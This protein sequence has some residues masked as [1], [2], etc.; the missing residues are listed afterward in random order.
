M[1]SDPASPLLSVGTALFPDNVFV[2]VHERAVHAS[3]LDLQNLT[4]R[5]Q[6]EPLFAPVNASAYAEQLTPVQV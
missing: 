2:N 6:W 1:P 4:K 5:A 3:Q